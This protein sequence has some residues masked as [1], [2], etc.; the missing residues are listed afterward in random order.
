MRS[1]T[2][3]LNGDPNADDLNGDPNADDLNG[4]RTID[5]G[6][7]NADD[8]VDAAPDSPSGPLTSA[9]PRRRRLG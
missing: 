3:D 8:G 7:P 5:D 4:D 6:D 1:P 9:P 2:D